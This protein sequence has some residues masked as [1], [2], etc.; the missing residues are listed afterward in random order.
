MALRRDLHHLPLPD[1]KAGRDGTGEADIGGP[2]A[3]LARAEADGI[4][5]SRIARS[6]GGPAAR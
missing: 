3:E 1:D 4:V 5:H 6:R 2:V